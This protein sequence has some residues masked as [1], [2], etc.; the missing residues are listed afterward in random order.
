MLR[1]FAI[2][3]AIATIRPIVVLF[4]ALTDLSTREFFG[5]AFWIG[6]SI[7]LIAAEIWIQ[8]TRAPGKG[9]RS[10]IPVERASAP[11]NLGA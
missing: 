9:R 3:L 8:H 11:A 1:A 4:F 7:H 6:F 2:G 10:E 5:I